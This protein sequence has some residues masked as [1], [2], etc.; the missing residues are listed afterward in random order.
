M[1]DPGI[2]LDLSLCIALVLLGW[3][4][5]HSSDHFQA[6]VLFITFGLILSLTWVRLEA[7]DIAIA[8]AAVGAGL[9]GVMLVD[10][11]RKI[12]IPSGYQVTGDWQRAARLPL[13]HKIAALVVVLILMSLLL[14]TVW[15]LPRTG[16]GLAGR[17]NSTLA[18]SG[19]EHPVTAVL[20]NFR[21]Y[22]TWLELGI[23]LLAVFG[24]LCIRRSSGL[25]AVALPAATTPILESMVM[26][27]TPF[28]LLV[29]GY[30]LWRG[31]FAPG[32]AFQAGVVLGAGS[33][34]LWM[35]GYPSLTILPDRVW[36]SLI[37]LGFLAFL[38]F[39]SLS[40]LA[41]GVF[42]AYDPVHGAVQILL[43]ETAATV[44]I[45]AG[46]AGLMLALQ[47][48]HNTKLTVEQQNRAA[49]DRTFANKGG[50]E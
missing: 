25:G 29:S 35:A 14:M 18:A 36:R 26:L 46:L 11:L 47:P 5:L 24:V 27:I 13:L 19:T 31:A 22:D 41:T 20:L 39:G 37:I 40:F 8:E 23:L 44:S 48:L 7:P 4:L 43:L 49:T 6:I 32:G 21:G 1:S 33:I 17:V 42:L 10:A 9:A 30:L 15:T 2:L 34:L 12:K 38:V 50:G 3:R 28:I 16:N 45:G